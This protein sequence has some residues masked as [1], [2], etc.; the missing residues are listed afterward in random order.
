[1]V[2]RSSPEVPSGH[3]LSRLT[4]G[5]VRPA[6]RPR[7]SKLRH[8][9]AAIRPPPLRARPPSAAPQEREAGGRGIQVVRGAITWSLT[10]ISYLLLGLSRPTV[11]SCSSRSRSARSARACSAAASAAAAAA[12]VAAVSAVADSACALPAVAA[13]AAAVAVAN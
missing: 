4:F 3:S 11:N 13:A 5:A 12:A 8:A 9:D 10:A 1:M 6:S 2:G 7:L